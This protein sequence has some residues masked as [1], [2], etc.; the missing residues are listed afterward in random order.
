MLGIVV[1]NMVRTIR[2]ISVERGH[3][4]RGFV[5]MP[6]GGAGPLH[7][8]EV[9]VS[10]GMTEMVVPAAP[11][12]V[13]AQ[14]LLVSDLKEDF[15]SSQRFRM[16]DDGVQV[17]IRMLEGLHDKATEWFDGEKVSADGRRFELVVDARYVGQRQAAPVRGQ[18]AGQWQSRYADTAVPLDADLEKCLNTDGIALPGT[19]T[20]VV[21]G[22]LMLLS[23][24]QM[25]A[26]YWSGDPNGRLHADGW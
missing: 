26:A 3:D 15:V 16:D 17:L 1:A 8:R 23:P 2:R 6:F 22:E 18:A 19:A 7:A 25:M 4:P 21:D 10:L 24:E 14:G 5:L 11:G 13:C 20:K 12:I 9:A